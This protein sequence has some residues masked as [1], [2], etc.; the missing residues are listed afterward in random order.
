MLAERTKADHNCEVYRSFH[1]TRAGMLR[2]PLIALSLLGF[3]LSGLPSPAEAADITGTA[4]VRAGDAVVIG[5][6]RIRLGGIDA[7]AVDQ[8]CL[9][10]KGERWTCGIAARDELA[11]YTE[12]K[13]WACHTRAIDRRGRTVARCDVGGEDIQKWL[14]RAGW[15][16]AYTRV[17]RD[18]EADDAAAREAKA[19]MWQGA[20]IAP[21]DWRERNKK[22]TILGATK[23]P[24]GAHAILLASASGPVAP[25]PDCTIKG[26]VNTAGEC[27]YHQPTSRWYT[28]IKMKISKGTRWFCSVDEA[29]AA[30]CRETRR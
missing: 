16:L 11:K 23:P 19:G 5:N 3:S 7:P 2:K 14:V 12:G 29:E 20:F 13:S 4:K 30:G 25:S 6:T 18:Y 9:N 1:H 21:W 10:N 24:D 17:S 15:A 27:I 8:L 22:T 26:N 28:Q